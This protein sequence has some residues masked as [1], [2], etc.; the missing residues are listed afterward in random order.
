MSVLPNLIYRFNIITIKILEISF[1]DINKFESI[2][3]EEKRCRIAKTILKEKCM[4]GGLTIWPPNL[5]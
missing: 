4:V 2:Y 3:G 5:L 1:V